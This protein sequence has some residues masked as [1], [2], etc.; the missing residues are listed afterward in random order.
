MI[1]V[2][3]TLLPLGHCTNNPAHTNKLQSAADAQKKTTRS[4][5]RWKVLEAKGQT[6][7]SVFVRC[8]KNIPI[9]LVYFLVSHLLIKTALWNVSW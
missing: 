8:T 4:V 9:Q 3:F 1:D 6:T 5:G 2:T 7:N